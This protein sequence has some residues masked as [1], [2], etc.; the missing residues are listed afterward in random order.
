MSI[1]RDKDPP[2]EGTACASAG[3][4]MSYLR[5]GEEVDMAQRGSKG[6]V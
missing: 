3:T 4:C 1:L 5:N 2:E 6:R